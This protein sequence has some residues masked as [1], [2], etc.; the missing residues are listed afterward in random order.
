MTETVLAPLRGGQDQDD[1][2]ISQITPFL[3]GDFSSSL[4][5]QRA[6]DLVPTLK[7]R[8]ARQAQHDRILPETIDDLQRAGFFQ[9]LQPRAFGGHE[10]SPIE[11]FEVTSILAEGDPSVGWVLGV[12][13]IHH[14]HL[15]FFDERAQAEV[16]SSNPKTLVSSPYAPQIAKRVE[17]GFRLSGRWSFSS[18][19]DYCD[20]ALLGANIEG[21][22]TPGPGPVGSHVLLLPRED[23]EIVHNWDVSG[24]R[25]TGSN[26]IIVE[27]AFVPDHRSL[28]WNEVHDRTAPGLALNT[29][30]LF[31]LPFF[32]V[33]SRATQA[34]TAL[35]ALKG[36]ADALVDFIR[37]K[38]R[39]GVNPA[40]SLALAEAYS[41][42][43]EAKGRLYANYGAVIAEAAGGN[44][45]SPERLEEFR[46]QSAYIPARAAR[47]GTELYR[48]AGGTGIYNKHPFGRYLTDLMATQTHAINDFQGR[49]VDW[50]GP[51]LDGSGIFGTNPP[52]VVRTANGN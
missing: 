15:G 42:V 9:M 26:D 17:G 39:K 33:F 2:M 47:Y 14:F 27:D 35:G 46:F 6:R 51:M 12:V 24:L 37:A 43:S 19:S 22:P 21:E 41:F 49:S 48:V 1:A 16:W 5:V 52:G 23:Y 32:Q 7:E 31:E 28:T 10:L 50:I 4:M 13:G 38:G 20:W 11:S 30:L 45:V 40:V 18:G 44:K 34:P 8:A 36:M 29:G 3:V 25:A